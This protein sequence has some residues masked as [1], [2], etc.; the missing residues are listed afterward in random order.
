MSSTLHK[1][2][3]K[4]HGHKDSSSTDTASTG[5]AYAN[6]QSSHGSA[7]AF[8]PGHGQQVDQQNAAP[9][10]KEHVHEHTHHRDNTKVHEEHD[11]TE[12]H[13]KVQPLKD[14]REEHTRHQVKD[15]GTEV[16]EHG[17]GGLDNKAKAELEGRRADIARQGGTTHD[18]SESHS[19]TAPRVDESHRTHHIE[20]TIPVIE[21]NIERPKE[22]EHRKEKVEI[23]HDKP[24]VHTSTEPTMSVSD[25]ENKGHHG[26]TH[27]SHHASSGV[28]TASSTSGT[29]TS[30]GTT[31]TEKKSLTQKIKDAF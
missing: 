18:H 3:D 17:H 30:D 4:L 1:I 13:Q 8:E 25:W 28:D 27:E 23:I 29:H 22:V 15:H 24:S 9:V 16:H 5:D 10:T 14:E 26:K 6:K 7:P 21:R 19:H 11:R 20:E 2:S 31:G 12:V